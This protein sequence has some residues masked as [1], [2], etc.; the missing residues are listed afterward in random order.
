MD[1]IPK[2]LFIFS[3]YICKQEY[4]QKWIL[5]LPLCEVILGHS[6]GVSIILAILAL[7]TIVVS[8]WYLSMLSIYSK[9]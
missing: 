5:S 8:K 4:C 6:V 3:F 2:K 9:L 7:G 1:Q